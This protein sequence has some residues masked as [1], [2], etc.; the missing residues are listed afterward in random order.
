M[1]L[2]W[3]VFVICVFFLLCAKWVKFS[4]FKWAANIVKF[5][6]QLCTTERVKLTASQATESNDKSIPFCIVHNIYLLCSLG[7]QTQIDANWQI[8]YTIEWWAENSILVQKTPHLM[9]T[10][11]HILQQWICRNSWKEFGHRQCQTTHM[12]VSVCII[13]IVVIT[14]CIIIT[15]IMA[16]NVWW[17]LYS[18]FNWKKRQFCLIVACHAKR[19]PFHLNGYKSPLSLSPLSLSYSIKKNVPNVKLSTIIMLHNML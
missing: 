1:Y 6:M 10:N 19:V 4:A 7:T 2:Q 12:T 17:I 11:K 14:M 5:Q 3:D 15:I 9:A 8:A 18:L 16:C 13:I